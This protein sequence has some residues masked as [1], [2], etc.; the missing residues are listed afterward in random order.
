MTEVL[1]RGAGPAPSALIVGAG[2]MGRWHAQVAVRSGA[3]IVGVVD[4]DLA[5][6]EA[7]AAPHGA[8]AF[9]SLQALLSKDRPQVA[10]VCTPMTTHLECCETLLAAGA[11]VL[12]E[13]PLAATA[14]EVETLLAVAAQHNRLLCPVHQFA[15][16]DGVRKIVGRL[17]EL[18]PIS[19]VA[20]TFHSA[21]GGQRRGKALDEIVVDIVP[22]AFS[23]LCRLWPSQDLTALQWQVARAAPGELSALAVTG[24]TTLSMM[25]SMSSRPTE[26]GVAVVGHHG[27]A[28]IDFFHGYAYILD[29]RVSRT[30]KILQ[31]FTAATRQ[32]LAAGSNL[33][34][35]AWRREA[36]YPGLQP[37][38]ANFY[39][40][41]TG[42]D[43]APLTP[44]EIVATYRARDAL[45]FS[46]C[47]QS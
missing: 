38:V 10:H 30:R 22:H 32:W 7:L 28:F 8:A 27:S 25:F 15:F 16:Q 20:F 6:A 46:A 34:L 19:R 44:G 42:S 37:L 35:R 41:A 9:S 2:L 43:L 47:V 17:A 3:R 29:G 39:R 12:C 33:A 23:V 13:K 11:H 36:A 26:A 21:G 45:L 18:G 14:A 1:G 4:H 40:A 5:R 24:D 31:P